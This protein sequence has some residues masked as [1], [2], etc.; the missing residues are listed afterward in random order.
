MTDKIV[1]LFTGQS[2]A[3][4]NI[5]VVAVLADLL[6]QAKSGELQSVAFAGQCADGAMITGFTSSD[7]VFSTIGAL[8]LVEHRLMENIES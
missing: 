7:D 8:R 3:T 2:T 4:P 5:Q 1:S 6:E